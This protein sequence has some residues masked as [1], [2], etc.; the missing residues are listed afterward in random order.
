MKGYKKG[1]H[2][3]FSRRISGSC[4]RSS[5]KLVKN[6]NFI[7]WKRSCCCTIEGD[8]NSGDGIV[9]GYRNGSKMQAEV[10]NLPMNS[11]IKEGET[12]VTS[13][14]GGY[15]PKGIRIGEVTI[16]TIR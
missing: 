5:L 14:L 11:T 15:Y 10:T 1:L 9:K 7:K 4:N 13:G 2:S 6:T 16:S 8:S 12:V 3:D